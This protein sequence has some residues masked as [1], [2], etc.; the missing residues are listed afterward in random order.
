MDMLLLLGNSSFSET[1]FDYLQFPWHVIAQRM[2]WWNERNKEN[3]NLPSKI[4]SMLK[5]KNR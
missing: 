3:G 1:Y 2:K 4:A 5:G